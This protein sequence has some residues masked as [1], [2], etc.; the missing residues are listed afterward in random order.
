[1]ADKYTSDSRNN[2]SIERLYSQES[3]SENQAYLSIQPWSS[4]EDMEIL[5]SNDFETLYTN[6]FTLSGLEKVD[7]PWDLRAK[8]NSI[9]TVN[10]LN[11]REQ[12]V[13][14]LN[15]WDDGPW[16]VSGDESNLLFH[17]HQEDMEDS[18]NGLVYYYDGEQGEVLK[19]T[20]A[21]KDVYGARALKRMSETDYFGQQTK[22]ITIPTAED[23]K[24]INPNDIAKRKGELQTKTEAEIALQKEQEVSREYELIKMQMA[25][26]GLKPVET[27]FGSYFPSSAVDLKVQQDE[28]MQ[29][30]QDSL[31]SKG[32]QPFQNPIGVQYLAGDDKLK[33]PQVL[34]IGTSLKGEE[35]RKAA[36]TYNAISYKAN[37]QKKADEK[38]QEDLYKKNKM[39]FVSGQQQLKESKVRITQ[40]QW[41]KAMKEA[42]TNGHIANIF[43]EEDAL[44]LDHYMQSIEAGKLDPVTQ[45]AINEIIKKYHVKVDLTQTESTHW[46]ITSRGER[47][48][49]EYYRS[50]G[51][52]QNNGRP[53]TT[54]GAY[55]PQAAGEY[56]N[57]Y[58]KE[59]YNTQFR[60]DA[61]TMYDLQ[62]GGKIKTA[63]EAAAKVK[64]DLSTLNYNNG[65][66]F[67]SQ[68]QNVLTSPGD[69]Y[70]LADSIESTIIKEWD[71]HTKNGEY[72]QG[73]RVFSVKDGDVYRLSYETV[74]A[75]GTH[76][77]T[78]DWQ[79]LILGDNGIVELSQQYTD[80]RIKGAL[81]AGNR[82]ANKALNNM[83]RA[84][85]REVEVQMQVIGR[86]TLVAPG[87]V[88]I[89]NI[90][91]RYSGLWYI[92]TCIHQI[93]PSAGYTTSLTLV[94]NKATAQNKIATVKV[95]AENEEQ[96]AI[97]TVTIESRNPDGTS[98]KVDISVDTLETNLA[99]ME[100]LNQQGEQEMALA[101]QVLINSGRVIHYTDENGKVQIDYNLLKSQVNQMEEEKQAIQRDIQSKTARIKQISKLSKEAKDA[102]AN[103]AKVNA[104]NAKSMKYAA[105]EIQKTGQQLNSWIQQGQELTAELPGLQS[106][107]QDYLSQFQGLTS[108]L[109]T[110]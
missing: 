22:G 17:N 93:D 99:I 24:Q 90:G 59:G 69:Y 16:Y 82:S 62:R 70:K 74:W 50:Y 45:A 88:K 36:H 33:L 28:S 63:S 57:F 52:Y 44:A 96:T 91:L 100:S 27:T 3:L 75:K 30:I 34:H 92:K 105:E 95:R 7:M 86:P 89:F 32:I 53:I 108:N 43:S 14:A 103:L 40:D 55:A 56:T 78:V 39:A 6:G 83:R 21:S 49:P 101:A 97:S 41:V 2:N 35:I 109:P 38:A 46:N 26:R 107:Y 84:K 64:A 42:I 5:T 15:E 87:M 79:D 4:D 47:I 71:A 66:T 8:L 19:V 94:K 110:V 98:V 67:A 80:A 65:G 18:E 81:D 29:A 85:F 51:S 106:Q 31:R 11:L 20:I 48:T 37:E 12:I 73:I 54:G 76:E 9:N 104:K 58:T 60:I 1:M 25:A 102:Q 68:V 61:G 10:Q 23:I 72:Y 13:A 77:T